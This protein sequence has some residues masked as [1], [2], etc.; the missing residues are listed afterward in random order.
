MVPYAAKPKFQDAG[1]K[2]FEEES[3][4]FLKTVNRAVMNEL[5][6]RQQKTSE[7]NAVVPYQGRGRAKHEVDLDPESLRKWNQLVKIYS[8][9]DEEKEDGEREQWWRRELLT[10]QGRIDLFISPLHQ[11]LQTVEWF[12][13][14]VGGRSFP[15]PKCCRPSSAAYMSLVAKFPVRSTSIQQE[16]MTVDGQRPVASSM[17]SIGPTFDSD[18]S[19]YF[20]TEPEPDINQGPKDLSAEKPY[21]CFKK[22]CKGKMVL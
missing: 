19:Q 11:E 20:V 7:I 17:A 15:Y 4:V 5:G 12:C 6:D 9:V 18:G 2:A 16:S 21:A 10:F 22:R 3:G 13:Y 14:G 8:R 1:P